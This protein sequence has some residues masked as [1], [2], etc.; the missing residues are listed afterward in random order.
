MLF[1]F[2]LIEMM[3]R[4]NALYLKSQ[5][6]FFFADFMP[7]EHIEQTEDRN[8]VIF[9]SFIDLKKNNAKILRC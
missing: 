8:P 3:K 2:N 5:I 1:P 9:F 4:L 6:D 7:F